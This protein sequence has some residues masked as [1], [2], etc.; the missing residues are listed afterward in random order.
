M[1]EI[2]N[3]MG[4]L[5]P[6]AKILRKGIPSKIQKSMLQSN[7]FMGLNEINQSNTSKDVGSH[8][9]SRNVPCSLDRLDRKV[10]HHGLG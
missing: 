9:S 6:F 2:S 7:I 3:H 4:D 1:K 10:R 5:A 8:S